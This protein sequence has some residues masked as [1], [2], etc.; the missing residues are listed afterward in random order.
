V[1][2]LLHM[3]QNK[4]DA[5][6]TVPA[7]LSFSSCQLWLSCGVDSGVFGVCGDSPQNKVD[8]WLH[9]LQA[10]VPGVPVIIVGTHLDLYTKATKKK[11]K[12]DGTSTAATAAILVEAG[13]TRLTRAG[14]HTNTD[15]ESTAVNELLS[16]IQSRY[17]RRFPNVLD[18]MAVS[19]KTKRG[20]KVNTRDTTRPTTRHD[21]HTPRETDW[22]FWRNTLRNCKRASRTLRRRR[23][24][25]ASRSRRPT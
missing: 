1:F 22:A 17:K 23:S 7:P 11:K 14:A 9:S 5:T 24:T 15:N 8:Y 4:S 6:A 3:L 18:V 2:N 21:T 19:T 25:W 16:K 13:V 10:R 20:V 12:K